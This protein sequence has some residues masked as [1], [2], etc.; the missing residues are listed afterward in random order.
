MTVEQ[1]IGKLPEYRKAVGAFLTPILPLVL[2]AYSDGVITAQE[3]LGIVLG[4]LGVTGV[5]LALPNKPAAPTVVSSIAVALPAPADVPDEPIDL[6]T[7][8]R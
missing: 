1:I 8:G 5:V 3:W 6:S 4:V 7:A 2:T